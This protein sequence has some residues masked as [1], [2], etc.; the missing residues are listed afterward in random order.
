MI[1]TKF[2]N[3]LQMVADAAGHL[4]PKTLVKELEKIRDQKVPISLYHLKPDRIDELIGEIKELKDSR[5]SI[6]KIGDKFVV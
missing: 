4:T 2:P 6:M 1:E 5:I 3:D